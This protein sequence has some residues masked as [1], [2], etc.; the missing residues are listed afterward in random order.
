MSDIER[1]KRAIH[2]S[3]ELWKLGEYKRALK[4]L[5]DSIA[6][7]I[8]ENRSSWIRTLSHHAAVIAS[9]A[10]DLRLVKHYYEQSLAHNPENPRAL[11]GLANVSLEQGE[12]EQAKRYATKCYEA[13]RQS[14]DE[15]DRG[16]LELLAK[17]WPEL[18]VAG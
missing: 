1:L 12:T 8:K 6:E 18:G 11:Y 9:S 13:I 14:D 16:L 15:I 5:D 10:G 3:N 17:Q 4:L 7:A 2:D